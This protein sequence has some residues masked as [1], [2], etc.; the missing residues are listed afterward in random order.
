M[1]WALEQILV[2]RPGRQTISKYAKG[3]NKYL[4]LF[5][6]ISAAF[7]GLALTQ[8]IATVT[9]FHSI[10]GSVSLL[11]AM[12]SLLKTGQGGEAL[13]VALIVVIIPVYLLSAAFDLWYKH[14]L[15]G[16]KFERKA[17]AL[18]RMGRLWFLSAAGVIG[19][20]YC[21]VAADQGSRFHYAV[22]F[23]L[24]SLLLMKFV[25]LRLTP[26]INAIR[27]VDGSGGEGK[28]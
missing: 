12:I 2:G 5:L 26:L 22:Y 15:H 24:I 11:S 4:G 28:S 14:E 20:L 23:L 6:M 1:H 25:F 13:A 7:L 3:Q 8:P 16:D 10:R 21:L 27:F 17:S 19:G 18:L 9:D